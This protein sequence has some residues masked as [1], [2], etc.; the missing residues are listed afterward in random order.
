MNLFRDNESGGE[1]KGGAAAGTLRSA[2][3]T[4]HGRRDGDAGALYRAVAPARR[5]AAPGGAPFAPCR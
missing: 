1:R 3:R 5:H 2:K 4:T